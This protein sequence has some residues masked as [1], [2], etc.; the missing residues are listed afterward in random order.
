MQILSPQTYTKLQSADPSKFPDL[1]N[2]YKSIFNE[3]LYKIPEHL[4]AHIENYTA[5]NNAALE[6]HL[7]WLKAE[8]LSKIKGNDYHECFKI[9][10]DIDQKLINNYHPVNLYNFLY[11]SY[12][13]SPLYCKIILKFRRKDGKPVNAYDFF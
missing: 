11:K 5:K 4:I 13:Y 3:D 8:N 9:T 2:E 12:M 1:G 7:K 10:A 6:M